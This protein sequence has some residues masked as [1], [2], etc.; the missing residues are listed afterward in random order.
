MLIYVLEGQFGGDRYEPWVARLPRPIAAVPQHF[1]GLPE[2]ILAF[3]AGLHDGIQTRLSGGVRPFV[4]M[5]LVGDYYE[6]DWPFEMYASPQWG[7]GTQVLPAATEQPD[8]TQIVLVADDGAA[9]R[10]CAVLD[11]DGDGIEGWYWFEGSMSREAD[12]W[13]TASASDWTLE[14]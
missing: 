2:G 11:A 5:E 10:L 14:D 12:I 4:R 6:P 3:H 7:P 1:Q 8:W 13:L 9:G